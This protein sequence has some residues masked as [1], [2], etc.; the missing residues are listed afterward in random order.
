MSINFNLLLLNDK[1]LD[2]HPRSWICIKGKNL[3]NIIS[4]I[5]KEI[6]KNKKTNRE[7]ISKE[8]SQKL[9]CNFV[10]IKNILRG[11]NQ[12]YPLPMILELI[13][14]TKKKN[15]YKKVIK[16]AIE[17][18]KVN[19]ASSKPIKSP[20]ILSKNIAKIIGAFCADGSLSMQF[21]LSNKDKQIIEKNTLK[22]IENPLIKKGLSRKEYYV[23]LQVNRDN[24]NKILEIS[25]K[26]KKFHIQTHYNLELTDE[27]KSN[28]EA[29]NRWLNKEFE[30]EPTIFYKKENAWRTIFSNKILARYLIKFFDI[31]PG[32]KTDIIDEPKIIKNSN[33]KMRKEFAKGVLMFDGCIT[34]SRKIMFS[35]LSPYLAES[36]REILVKDNLKVGNFKNK[37]GEHIVYT[38]VDNKSNKLL[39][40]F[41]K[42]TKKWELLMWLNKKNFKSKQIIFKKELRETNNIFELLKKVKICDTEFLMKQLN[43]S[44][45]SIRQHLLILKNKEIIRLSNK[46]NSLNDYVSDKITIFLKKEF[47]NH[48]FNR[49]FQKFNSYE[50]FAIFLEIHKATLSAWKV[51]KNR[52]PLSILKQF[53]KIFDISQEEIYSNVKETDREIAEII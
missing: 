35:S 30:I 1:Y 29:F 45:T 6:I 34:K 3:K 7:Q 44:C 12:F 2:K 40:Y 21:V 36:I 20:N 11:K 13:K 5:E 43:Y 50:K 49:I 47:H 25:R 24:Y 22:F 52:I 39:K 37:R 27:H 42:G 46:P 4:K 23:P 26:N 16:N 32:Y 14:L 28:V 31:L 8:L 33:L 48:L 51:R 53:C 18:L 17:Y 15:N 41:E 10:S 38:F 19:S 9:F